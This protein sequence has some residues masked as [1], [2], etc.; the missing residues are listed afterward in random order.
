M[1]PSELKNSKFEVVIIRGTE[2]YSLVAPVKGEVR[3]EL[4]TVGNLEKWMW[5]LILKFLVQS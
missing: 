3:K 1:K 5:R 2:I 4:L